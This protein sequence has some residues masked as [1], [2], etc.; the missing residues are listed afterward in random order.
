MADKNE[1]AHGRYL[2]TLPGCLSCRSD[3]PSGNDIGRCSGGGGG[4]S[5][6]SMFR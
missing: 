1:E 4:I 5:N 2:A 3:N 6:T